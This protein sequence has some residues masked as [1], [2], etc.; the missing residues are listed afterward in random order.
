MKK[1]PGK[2]ESGSKPLARLKII[3]K[4]IRVIFNIVVLSP[5][6]DNL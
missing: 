4:K 2:P 3:S 5:G 1:D 6:L